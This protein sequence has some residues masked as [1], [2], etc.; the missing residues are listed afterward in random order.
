MRLAEVSCGAPTGRLFKLEPD[1]R[2]DYDSRYR[3]TK[4]EADYVN[5]NRY[6][7]QSK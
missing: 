6:S 2:F 4:P 5:S 7:G 3:V 1:N